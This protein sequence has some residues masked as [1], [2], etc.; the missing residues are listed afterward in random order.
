MKKIIAM[1][2]V[3]IIMLVSSFFIGHTKECLITNIQ[4]EKD[5]KIIEVRTDDKNFYS[6][7]VDKDSD[8]K[9]YH[10]V[11]VMF[12]YNELDNPVD[13]EIIIAW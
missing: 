13:D 1:V 5:Y 12:K 11:K 7:K 9:I 8:L 2:M 6:F 10:K 3:M 4:T